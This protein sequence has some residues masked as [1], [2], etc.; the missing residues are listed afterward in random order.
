MTPKIS[1]SMHEVKNMKLA[2]SKV[3]LLTSCME[4]ESKI[5]NVFWPAIFFAF[6]NGVVLPLLIFEEG[7]SNV[8][9]NKGFPKTFIL[10]DQLAPALEQ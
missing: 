4:F 5:W 2:I 10:L 1:N 8:G 7:Q 6:S 9:A 3:A